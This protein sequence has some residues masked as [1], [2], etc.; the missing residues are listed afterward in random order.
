MLQNFET[1]GRNSEVRLAIRINMIFLVFVITILLD[2]YE[3]HTY[4]DTYL[5]P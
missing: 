5:E 1:L 2:T 3:I 4:Q